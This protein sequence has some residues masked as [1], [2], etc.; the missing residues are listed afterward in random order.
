MKPVMSNETL[1]QA[2]IKELDDDPEVIAKHI[3]VNAIDGAVTLAGHVS[4][5]HEKHVAV[6]AAERVDAVRSVADEIEVRTPSLHERADD[7][8]AEEIAHLRA[9]GAEVPDS[10]GA[11]I[12][13]GRVILHGEVELASQRD[14][15]ERAVRQLTGVHVVDNLIKVTSEAKPT[16]ADVEQRVQDAVTSTADLHARS[17][18]VS[19]NNGTAHLSGHVPSSAALQVVLH[20]AETV[21]GVTAVHS[22]IVVTAPED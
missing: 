20:A 14:A 9:W 4:A 5:I 6:R 1:R 21:P 2:V 17:I 16:A 19:M 11:Q 22:E 18:R 7:E 13:D 3:W 12:R 10:V 8:I 15:A